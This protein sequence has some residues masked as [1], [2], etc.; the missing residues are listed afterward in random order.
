[1]TRDINI[2]N[3]WRISALSD[4]RALTSSCHQVHS[5]FCLTFS[6]L[7]T[8]G[9]L[10]IVKHL[11]SGNN[12]QKRMCWEWKKSFFLH[13]QQVSRNQ[14]PYLLQPKCFNALLIR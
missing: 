13:L 12:T 14:T 8:L 3:R 4:D 1:M 9:V 5:V 11:C 7:I 6:I 2:F 10:A